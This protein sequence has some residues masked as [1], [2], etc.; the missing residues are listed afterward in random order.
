MMKKI[1]AIGGGENG[2][3]LDDGSQ[4][5]YET[6]IMDK[7]IIRLTNKKTPNYLFL[8]HA[9]CFSDEIQNSYYDTMKKIYGDKYGCNCK[10]LKASDL[11]NKKLV[12]E[13]VDWADIIYEGGGDTDAMIKLWKKSGFD[14]I[15]RE[16]WHRGKV[17]CGISAGAVCW[18]NSCNSDKEEM[19]FESVECLNWFDVFVTPHC[20]EEGRYES[21]KS[22]LKE[23]KM[24]GLML[25]NCSAIEIVDN[26][27]KIISGK[28]NGRNFEKGYVLKCYWKNNEYY[29]E[30]LEESKEYKMLGEL[31]STNIMNLES[32]EDG[33]D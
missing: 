29:E 24:L 12:K 18:F 22:Q 14:T 30:K 6:E 32:E 9:M 28:G 17:I 20:D 13:V 25:S 31:F 10:Y 1:V 23:N 8:A 2:R 26:K 4:T 11:Y 27:Y 33:I 7:E 5:M 3:F 21:T 15:L 16:A 19:R